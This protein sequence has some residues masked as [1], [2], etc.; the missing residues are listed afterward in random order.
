ML[1]SGSDEEQEKEEGN[2]SKESVQPVKTQSI[3][4]VFNAM[5]LFAYTGDG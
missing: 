2:A 4:T 5:S 1:D 3:P